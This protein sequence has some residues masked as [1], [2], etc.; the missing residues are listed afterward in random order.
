MFSVTNKSWALHIDNYVELSEAFESD[1]PIAML[2]VVQW[3]K[4]D[5]SKKTW[6]VYHETD[7]SN[8][9]GFK[10]L[11]EEKY[12]SEMTNASIRHAL[13]TVSL[14]ADLRYKYSG[15]FLTRNGRVM[16]KV[17]NKIHRISKDLPIEDIEDKILLQ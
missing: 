15:D 14:S 13:S 12:I 8:W 7:D 9:D 17:V 3:T 5:G 1:N 4:S 6:H 2:Q 16:T 10:A 11:M